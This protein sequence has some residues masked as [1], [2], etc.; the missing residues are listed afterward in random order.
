MYLLGC[1]TE[2]HD[3]DSLRCLSK[4]KWEEGAN[5]EG[6]KAKDNGRKRITIKDIFL[7]LYFYMN[8]MTWQWRGYVQNQWK[9]NSLGYG[10][11]MGYVMRGD[12]TL[13]TFFRAQQSRRGD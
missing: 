10:N 13:M 12:G 8:K 9:L 6:G 2:Y 5:M 11:W 3:E 7:S 4:R 1:Q